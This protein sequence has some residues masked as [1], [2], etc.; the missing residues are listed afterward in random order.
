VREY[1]LDLLERSRQMD[2]I[3]AGLSP[4][5][6]LALQRSAQAWA[7]AAARNM[8][9]PEDVQAVASSVMA[10]RLTGAGLEE[11][12]VALAEK[13]VRTVPVR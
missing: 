12:G 6:G 5:A 11:G 1:I 10:H 2:G 13:I 7:F 4:R 8:V 9:V 3:K